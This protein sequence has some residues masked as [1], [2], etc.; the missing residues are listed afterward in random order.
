MADTIGGAVVL[1]VAAE[2]PASC[3]CRPGFWGR[4]IFGRSPCWQLVVFSEIS[5]TDDYYVGWGLEVDGYV[6]DSKR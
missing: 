3:I 2:A 1:A 6:V 5:I 4:W